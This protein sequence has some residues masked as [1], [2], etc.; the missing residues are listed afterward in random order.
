MVDINQNAK[1]QEKL[2]RMVSHASKR[3]TMVDVAR[4]QAMKDVLFES[5]I[6]SKK[7]DVR[8]YRD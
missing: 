2:S 7:K 4:K 8:Q 6:S 3:Q 5:K 1:K